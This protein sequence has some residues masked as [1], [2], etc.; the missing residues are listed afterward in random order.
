MPGWV[1]V[2]VH[3]SVCNAHG[4]R[5]GR[6][7]PTFPSV[8]RAV[9]G[10]SIFDDCASEAVLDDIQVLLRQQSSPPPADTH[11][12]LVI[13]L[14]SAD[15]SDRMLPVFDADVMSSPLRAAQVARFR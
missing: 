3:A 14:D 15:P 13:A 2:T 12:V 11:N 6:R 5:P 4:S 7:G 9:I 10:L 1:L 8:P